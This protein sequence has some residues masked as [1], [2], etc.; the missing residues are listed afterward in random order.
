M[1]LNI[2]AFR[3]AGGHEL[4]RLYL[5]SRKRWTDKK[6]T[7]Q[8]LEAVREEALPPTVVGIW[9]VV[10]QSDQALAQALH[11]DHSYL[12]RKLAIKV[13]GRRM[14]G[15]SWEHTWST[16]GNVEGMLNLFARSSVLQIK[17]AAVVIGNCS[18]GQRRPDREHSIEELLCALVPYYYTQT[19]HRSADE[20]PLL[21]LYARMIPA[22]SSDFVA[23]ILGQSTNPLLAHV[24]LKQITKYHPSLVQDRLLKSVQLAE[25]DKKERFWSCF[26]QLT[27]IPSDQRDSDGFSP[28]MSYMLKLLEV[29]AGRKG[30]GFP[31]ERTI[32]LISGPLLR[33]AMRNRVADNQIMHIIKSVLTYMKQRPAAAQLCFSDSGS[34]LHSLATYWSRKGASTD[35]TLNNEFVE[36]LCLQGDHQ[37]H[38]EYY[39]TVRVIEDLHL[40][41]SRNHRYPLLCHI[42]KYFTKPGGDL[43]DTQIGN[44]SDFDRWSCQWFL[45]M[46]RSE[47][48]KSL[49]RLLRSR[50]DT[51]FLS[52]ERGD[53][54][55]NHSSG[56]GT[57]HADPELLRIFLER[58]HKEAMGQAEKS[59]LSLFTVFFPAVITNT[60]QGV[61]EKQNISATSRE[62]TDRAFFAK[63]AMLYAIAS[64]SLKLYGDV[65]K[66][67]RRYVRDPVRYLSLAKVIMLI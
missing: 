27:H 16:L 44:V 29:L 33:R 8:V 54:I 59:I 67:A 25:F 18:K 15:A 65:L 14:K 61:R 23:E 2:A 13:M 60:Y 36:F 31:A 41:V 19:V 28:S 49:K 39:D 30:F 51:K 24:D 46:D 40:A 10:S 45:N 26:P 52:L 34:F 12:V 20:R 43:N 37:T 17:Q 21:H 1:S 7:N 47:A 48:A 9:L 42:Y 4:A 38:G 58:G 3:D 62:P 56:L 11:Q 32:R 53:S 66:W 22:C 64:G 63:S 35:V 50:K 5:E 55:F 6:I 57:N